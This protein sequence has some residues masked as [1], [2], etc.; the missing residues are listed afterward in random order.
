MKNTISS[1]Q[2]LAKLIIPNNNPQSIEPSL[3]VE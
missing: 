2:V 3:C 1:N